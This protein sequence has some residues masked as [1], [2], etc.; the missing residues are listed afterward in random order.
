MKR[1]PD[2]PSNLQLP[3]SIPSPAK[4]SPAK[5]QDQHISTPNS[6]PQQYEH[7]V[8]S[9]VMNPPAITHGQNQQ[10]GHEPFLSSG[11]SGQTSRMPSRRAEEADEAEDDIEIHRESDRSR[12]MS[13][14]SDDNAQA[15][16]P[17][18]RVLRLRSARR[19]SRTSWLRFSRSLAFPEW[20]N[21]PLLTYT[22]SEL[23]R[24]GQTAGHGTS[25]TTLSGP[26][27]EG[28]EH[29]HA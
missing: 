15:L 13:L 3:Q 29:F 24:I 1:F 7:E 2:P 19:R 16:I 27:S 11:R 28:E 21:R 25:A 14:E 18:V 17:R 8:D 6:P 4:T 22:A 20:T 10:L 9:F 12:S 26:G 5:G 23:R